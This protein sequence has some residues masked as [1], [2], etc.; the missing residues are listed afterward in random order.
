M[1]IKVKLIILFVVL[2]TI[3]LFFVSF[4]SYTNSK[5][6]LEQAILSK[7]HLVTEFR[8]SEILVFL[9][10]I[11]KRTIH[12]SSEP[13]IKDFVKEAADVNKHEIGRKFTKYL[14]EHEA[15]NDKDIVAIDVVD[16]SGQVI[17]S[18]SPLRIGRDY[19]KTSSFLYGRNKAYVSDTIRNEEGVAGFSV[20]VPI[21]SYKKDKVIG[22]WVAHYDEDTLSGILT[23]ERILRLG[24]MT[25]WRGVGNTGESY[26]VNQDK[27]MITESLFLE[28]AIL[29][30][31]VGTYPVNKGLEENKEV[32][33]VWLD[34]RGIP[35][36]GVSM[37]LHIEDFTWV[38]LSEQDVSEAIIPAHDLRKILLMIVVTTALIIILITL[39]ISQSIS[40][41]IRAL[42]K[43]AK[44][45]GGGNLNYKVG[46]KDKD[47]IGQLSRDFD[48]MT[49][50]LQ[51][52]TASRDSLNKEISIRKR[53][54]ADLTSAKK[55]A[56]AASKA[57][58]DFLAS[59]SHELRTPLNA[60]IGFSEVLRD[61]AFGPFNDKQ[62]E[63]TVDVLNSGKHLL[64]LINDILDLSKIEAGKTELSLSDFDLKAELENS[65]SMI[66][67]KALKHNI[68]IVKNI[69]DNLGVVR[70]DERKFK[71]IMF[72]LLSNAAKFTPD[73]GKIG[74]EA[75]MEDKNTILITVW[76]TGIGIEEKN[77]DKVFK[78]FEQIDSSHSRKYAGT[79]L[80]MP[81]AKRFVELH[82][83][84]LWFESKGKDQGTYFYFT[85]PLKG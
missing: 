35:V 27:F 12:F 56:E 18:S 20:S 69:S 1:L 39:L 83:G 43:G 78:E 84:K 2:V 61:E 13:A 19:S 53:V 68:S 46:T 31:R 62:K 52:T 25:Q 6:A 44:I 74:I 48:K 63:Y 36:I 24:A 81:L 50:T 65:L 49:N 64:S 60:I 51:K 38:L 75:K 37:V 21:M 33:G 30:Q 17:I 54:E 7:L 77:K 8:E 45:I 70:A 76:D 29:N 22:V 55:D 42:Q 4:I 73:G 66:K 40:D 10:N 32:K 72:N 47:E 85:L 15:L 28:D 5:D 3:P 82:K 41:P 71:Q 16:L 26:I 59:M 80:G 11:K 58:S 9:E 14:F 23:G 34:Y 67:E 79:G 57:K